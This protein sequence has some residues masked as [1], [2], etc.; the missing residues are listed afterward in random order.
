MV[1]ANVRVNATGNRSLWF[2]VAFALRKDTSLVDSAWSCRQ[3]ADCDTIDTM[4]TKISLSLAFLVFAL[5]GTC[6]F[7]G[8]AS[9]PS[10]RLAA[11]KIPGCAKAHVCKDL[12]YGE[13]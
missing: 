12:Q 5:P 3:C 11:E 4:K 6:V 13:R 9:M 2:G 10:L 1:L 8:D 7:A